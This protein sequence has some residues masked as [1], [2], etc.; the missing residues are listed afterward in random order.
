M[1]SCVRGGRR[2]GLDR[3]SGSGLNGGR[4]PVRGRLR[5]RDG[6]V[7]GSTAP[8]PAAPAPAGPRY[9]QRGLKNGVHSDGSCGAGSG[10]LSVG[11]G[12][13]P[14]SVNEYSDH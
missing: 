6:R 13:A 5:I 11:I 8:A 3:D 1:H 4:L 10:G 7:R 12:T 9:H 2:A 14:R